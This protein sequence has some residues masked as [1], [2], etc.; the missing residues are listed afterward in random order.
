V[1]ACFLWGNSALPF[2]WWRG[3]GKAVLFQQLFQIMFCMMRPCCQWQVNPKLLM[4]MLRG[5]PVL[6][7]VTISSKRSFISHSFLSCGWDFLD[8]PI[9][10]TIRFW[11]A[12]GDGCP[13]YGS[14]PWYEA[15]SS[16]KCPPAWCCNGQQSAD[17]RSAS[18]GGFLFEPT[19]RW[20]AEFSKLNDSR[21]N[22]LREKGIM[23]CSFDSHTKILF[24]L[25]TFFLL[26]FARTLLTSLTTAEGIS[27]LVWTV[28]FGCQDLKEYHF[29]LVQKNKFSIA[30]NPIC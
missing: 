27:I 30:F 4:E 12:A 5:V 18:L 16:S 23:L 28:T 6:V 21:W 2:I 26:D 15:T 10:L 9:L 24:E 7:W 8:V 25:D 11:T 29:D 3:T 19:W 20:R 13:T 22:S 17:V 1:I 14:Y